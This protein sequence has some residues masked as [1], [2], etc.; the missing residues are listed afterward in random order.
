MIVYIFLYLLCHF[1]FFCPPVLNPLFIFSDIFLTSLYLCF[2]LLLPALQVRMGHCSLSPLSTS[3]ST[4]TWV[5]VSSALP[6]ETLFKKCDI[7]E[8]LSQTPCVC[9]QPLDNNNTKM[10]TQKTE[11]LLFKLFPL[12]VKNILLTSPTAVLCWTLNA[13]ALIKIFFFN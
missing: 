1:Y 12:L 5:M 6:S 10:M 4:R 11:L 8:S 13:A 9:R 2:V 3:A 7:L